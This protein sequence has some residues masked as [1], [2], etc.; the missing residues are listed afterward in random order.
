MMA[1]N[2]Y[3]SFDNK[4]PS[5][6]Q[7]IPEK[8]NWDNLVTILDLSTTQV[9]N[10]DSL[11]FHY[12]HPLTHKQET[13]SNQT[14]LDTLMT[15]IKEIP[16][17]GLFFY[18]GDNSK[19]NQSLVVCNPFEK[20]SQLVKQH[21]PLGYRESR[22]VGILAS[23]MASSSQENF[24][25]ELSMLGNLISRGGRKM[26]K[27]ARH[28]NHG[29]EATNEAEKTEDSTSSS[30]S[31]SEGDECL[32]ERGR[33]H[34][35]RHGRGKHFGPFGKYD[36]HRKH[37]RRHSEHFE[38]FGGHGGPFGGHGGPFDGHGG[39]FGGHGGPFGGHGGQYP[40]LSK[41]ESKLMKKLYHARY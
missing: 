12:L 9:S 2:I 18:A 5:H 35:G 36:K 1:L 26:H 8:F 29:P 17:D 30:S 16:Y 41:K 14:Q 20:L 37:G 23:Q 15:D 38:P 24:E 33:H 39:P 19:P 22:W 34:I 32:K 11:V 6:F 28:I 7:L 21:Q 4:Q 27:R 10:R 31:E 40:F 3:I 13:I 25:T